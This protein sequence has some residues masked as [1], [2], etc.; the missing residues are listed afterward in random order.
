MAFAHFLVLFFFSVGSVGCHFDISL[1]LFSSRILL[2][3]G[4][5]QA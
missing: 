5:V 4:Q 1:S 2:Q 3:E